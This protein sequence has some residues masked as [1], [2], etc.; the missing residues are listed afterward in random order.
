[1][2][3][4]I[5]VAF[6]E[7]VV[8]PAFAPL[9]NRERINSAVFVGYFRHIRFPDGVEHLSLTDRVLDFTDADL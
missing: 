4:P 9:L 8:F 5:P 6:P 1:M 7:R 2:R 3:L